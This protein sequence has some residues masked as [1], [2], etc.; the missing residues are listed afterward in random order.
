MEIY[1]AHRSLDLVEADEVETLE[2]G[3]GNVCDA[4]V[5]NQ[6]VFFPSHEQM[7]PLRVI[8]VVEVLVLSLTR[9]RT[10]CWESIPVLHVHLGV[11]APFGMSCLKSILCA[12]DLSLKVGRENALLV[13]Q[14]FE[15]I[16]PSLS[17]RTRAIP[18]M[19]R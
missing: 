18:S 4:V 7:L 10:P 14:A 6:K 11:G 3:A 5:G 15:C 12:N 19:R 2:A 17:T 13:S 1:A 16:S 8:P 9:K